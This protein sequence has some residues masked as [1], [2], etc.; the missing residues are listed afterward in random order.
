MQLLLFAEQA[1]HAARAFLAL[2]L[3]FQVARRGVREDLAQIHGVG[4][5]VGVERDRFFDE[6]TASF[7]L[8]LLVRQENTELVRRGR[9]LRSARDVLLQQGDGLINVARFFRVHRARDQTFLYGSIELRSRTRP[10]LR[11]LARYFFDQLLEERAL[12]I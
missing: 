12:R 1:E 3:L 9:V 7:D 6:R 10:C 5:V 11:R 2:G 8:A 4:S